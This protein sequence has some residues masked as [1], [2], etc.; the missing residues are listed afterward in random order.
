MAVSKSAVSATLRAMGVRGF[1]S[2]DTFFTN[3]LIENKTNTDTG[4]DL[5]SPFDVP[6]LGGLGAWLLTG[7]LAWAG[8]RW[9]V[10]AARV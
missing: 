4:V 6:A 10:R 9:R 8:L 3:G 5:S 7:L 1:A 2:G